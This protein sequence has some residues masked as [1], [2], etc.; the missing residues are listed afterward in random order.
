MM[1]EERPEQENVD[2]ASYKKYIDAEVILHVP[3]EFTRRATVRRHV[4]DLDGAKLGTYHWKPLMDTW[5]YE[6]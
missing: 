6:L 2:D 1:M 3:G 5:Q 4:E